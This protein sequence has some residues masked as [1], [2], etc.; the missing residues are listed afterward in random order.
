MRLVQPGPGGRRIAVLGRIVELGEAGPRIMRD[1]AKSVLENRIDL[2]FTI[3]G[4]LLDLRT[5]LPKE[6]LAPHAETTAELSLSILDRVRPGDIV[7][8]KASHRF[9]DFHLLPGYLRFGSPCGK[10]EPETPPAR[11]TF[12][13]RLLGRPAKATTLSVLA[14]ADPSVCFLGDTYFGETH[15]AARR[16][17]GKTNFL[18]DRGYGYGLRHFQKMLRAVDASIAVFRAPL[19]TQGQ[20]PFSGEKKWLLKAEPTKTIKTLKEHNILALS[21]ANSNILDYGVEGLRQSLASLRAQSMPVIGASYSA[22]AAAQ[23]LRLSLTIGDHEEQIAIFAG[24]QNAS[25]LESKFG[26][27]AMVRNPRIADTAGNLAPAIARWR[28]ENPNRRIVA[29]VQWGNPY[30]W[31]NGGQMETADRLIEAGADLIVGTGAHLCQEIERRH[32]KWVIYNLGNFL[33]G[34]DGLYKT[35]NANGISMVARLMM[36]ASAK[37]I[38]YKLRLYPIVTNNNLTLFQP[39]FVSYAEYRNFLEI[40][41]TRAEAEGIVEFPDSGGRDDFGWYLELDL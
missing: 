22:S 19:T 4:E 32:G 25:Q 10:P 15:Q 34:S 24:L 41:C 3:H 40:M 20:S 23:P 1:M 36:A 2:V 21:L 29:F 37:S 6:M 18:E 7:F 5:A 30:K 16:K 12:P 28:G 14:G 27:R 33:F 38:S 39:R 8:A 31:R 26:G 11:A 17:R 35:H 9:S 13:G